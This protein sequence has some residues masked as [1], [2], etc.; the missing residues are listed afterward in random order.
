MRS[1]TRLHISQHNNLIGYQIV[2][3]TTNKFASLFVDFLNVF[4]LCGHPFLKKYGVISMSITFFQQQH[5][6]LQKFVYKRTKKLPAN[7]IIN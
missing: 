2:V 1:D 6:Q 7:G 5:T 3:K 4:L